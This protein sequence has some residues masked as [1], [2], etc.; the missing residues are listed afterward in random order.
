MPVA[1]IHEDSSSQF[2][3]QI[4]DE[5]TWNVQPILHEIRHA[6]AEL[7]E[8]G[9]KH[10][11]DLRSIPLAPGEEAKIL[12]QLGIGEVQA[13]LDAL[14]PSEVIETRYTGVWLITHY[15]NDDEIISRLI[16]ITTIPEIL[17][18]PIEDMRQARQ[19]LDDLLEQQHAEPCND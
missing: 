3:I 17:A 15:N 8:H 11:I 18:S 19:Q 9:T 2:N 10:I 7:I 4:G 13:R 6:L 1:N 5:L 14:G 16:E 12:E